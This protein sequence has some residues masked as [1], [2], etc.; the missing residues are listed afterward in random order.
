MVST[1]TTRARF[2]PSTRISWIRSGRDSK[3]AA[4]FPQRLQ[5]TVQRPR[6]LVLHF[7]VADLSRAVAGFQVV[8]LGRVGD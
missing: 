5:Y 1:A 7:D 2:E 6:Q 4:P 3:F 8:D